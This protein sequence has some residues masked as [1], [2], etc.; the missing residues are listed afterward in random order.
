[1][2][3]FD[4]SG[5]VALVTGSSRGICRAIALGLARHGADVAVNGFDRPDETAA[6]AGEVR[7][8]GRRTLG[9][10]ADLSTLD[11][12]DA[13]V[14]R[15]ERELGPIDILVLG[16]AL[17]VRQPTG[18]ID[19]ATMD[20]Q[21]ALNFRTIVHLLQRLV[22]PMA[23]RGWGRVL[24][25][26]SIQ[27][28]RPSAEMLVYAATKAAQLN[29]IRNMA[30]QFSG[31][32]VTLNNLAP[33]AILT[34]RNRSSLERPGIAERVIGCIPVGRLGEPDDCVGPALMLCSEAG[35]YVTG[36]N[37]FVDGGWNI[38]Q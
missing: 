4:L 14:D 11:A 15:V 16:A 28:E 20:A 12:A 2:D 18:G 1:M 29:M 25:I 19:V 38:S 23:E 35:R 6:T 22:P 37:L 21:I 8:L 10:D 3:D 32:G 17:E 5:R 24:S 7:A 26:G 34:E 30:R 36:A 33:G 27:Q 13:L 9:I 31:R